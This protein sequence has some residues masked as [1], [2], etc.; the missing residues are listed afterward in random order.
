M[1]QVVSTVKDLFS[2]P[3][4]GFPI[5]GSVQQERRCSIF[6]MVESGKTTILGLLEIICID[7]A[8]RFNK[9]GIRDKDKF[10]ILIEEHTSGI[11]QAG[12]ELRQ[13]MF[14]IKTPP[15]HIFDAYF[16]MRFGSLFGKT[17]LKLPFCETAGEAFNAI[18]E[19]FENGQYILKPGTKDATL[20][21]DYILNT[22]A[23]ALIAPVP[24]VLGMEKEIGAKIQHPDVNLSRLLSSIQK[25]KATDASLSPETAKPLRGI[26]VF[27]TKYDAARD[28][29]ETNHMDL[30]TKDGRH[31]FMSQY[32]PETYAVLGWYGLDNVAFWPTGVEIE[33]KPNE[34]GKMAPF[35]HP[36]NPD[37]GWKIKTHP[38]RNAPLGYYEQPM[39]EFIDWLK[40][41]VMA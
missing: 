28:W 13:G 27:F 39:L 31:A 19:Q 24:R 15:D 3:K 5:L 7:Y 18:L 1:S 14:P 8:N 38:K 37:R 26:A 20:I 21:R 11:R 34:I 10:K 17:I 6:G 30:T 2:I 9:P 29:L 25:Y 12:S 36:K 41:T 40:N 35:L 4:V 32:F 22:D 23:V 16:Y 33:Q